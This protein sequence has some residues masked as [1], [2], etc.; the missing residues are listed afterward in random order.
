VNAEYR[1]RLSPASQQSFVLQG[2]MM[3]PRDV[4]AFEGSPYW[5]EAVMLRRWDDQAKTAGLVVPA[6]MCYRPMIN[7]MLLLRGVVDEAGRLRTDRV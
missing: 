1:A 4:E 3:T 5:R 2:G 7:R 6:L